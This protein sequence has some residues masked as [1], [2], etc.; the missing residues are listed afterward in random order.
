MIDAT[1]RD[2]LLMEQRLR[3]WLVPWRRSCERG[4]K[5]GEWRVGSLAGCRGCVRD[6][7]V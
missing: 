3:R 7:F 6:V 4:V 5:E 1:G 2:K